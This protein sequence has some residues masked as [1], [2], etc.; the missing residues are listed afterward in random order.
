MMDSHS[1]LM[2]IITVSAVVGVFI[3]SLG[4]IFLFLASIKKDI[5]HHEKG[6]TEI[7]SILLNQNQ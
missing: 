4:Y 2:I 7:K 5:K 3:S 1:V 6:Q